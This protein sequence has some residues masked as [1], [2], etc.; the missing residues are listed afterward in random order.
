VV[1]IA[2]DPATQTGSFVDMDDDEVMTDADILSKR[3]RHRRWIYAG[4]GLVMVA[5]LVMG[6]LWAQRKPIAH[7]YLQNYLEDKGVKAKFDIKEIGTRFQRIENLVLGDPRNPDL[8]AEW[9]EIDTVANFSGI[10]IGAIRAK[11]VRLRGAYRD[12]KVSFG[13]LDQLRSTST[14]KSDGFP[15]MDVMIADARVGLDTDFGQVGMRFDG[16]GNFGST[17][18]GK[19]ALTAP[20]L[21]R[22]DCKGEGAEAWLDLGI[23]D[24]KLSVKGPVRAATV[25]CGE[26]RA[27]GVVLSLDGNI[28]DRFESGGGFFEAKV[29][30]LAS[31][32]AMLDNVS[33]W[34]DFGGNTRSISG[35]MKLDVGQSRL[36]QAQLGMTAIGAS[37]QLKRD[38][39]NGWNV[40]ANGTVNADN[41]RPDARALARMTKF[42]SAGDGTP[43]APLVTQLG[44]AIEGLG[45][46]SRAKARFDL[47]HQNGNG[48]FTLNGVEVVSKSGAV[49]TMAGRDPVRYLWR[50]GGL[51]VAGQA[52]L[53][54][55]GFPASTVSLASSDG[56]FSGTATIAPLTAGQ[57]RL[58]LSPVRFD[59][60]PN[61]T[62]VDTTA[63]FD[64][65]MNGIK[66]AGLQVPLSL[67]PGASP[68]NGCRTISLNRL[69]MA[70]ASFDPLSL[71]T[72]ISGN[73]VQVSQ[74]RASGRYQNAPFRFAGQ[75]VSFDMTRKIADIA[76]LNVS[77]S[78][79][80][81][82]FSATAKRAQVNASTQLA[83]IDA[84]EIKA[85]YGKAPVTIKGQSAQFANG[86]F[87]LK[88][89]YAHGSASGMSGTLVSNDL[90]YDTKAQALSASAIR[91]NGRAGRSPF[92][93]NAAQLTGA[94]RDFALQNAVVSYGEGASRSALNLSQLKGRMGAGGA[95]G[96]FTG[97]LINIAN[98]PVNMER[99][100]GQWQFGKGALSLNGVSLALSDRLAAPRYV[101]MQMRDFGMN[102]S[103]QGVKGAGG[104]FEPSTGTRIGAVDLD[105]SWLW[106]NGGLSLTVP[107]L[108]FTP[109]LQPEQLTSLTKGKIANVAGTVKGTGN[110]LW[111][112][113]DG[114][115]STGRFSTDGMDLAA[116]FGPVRQMKGTIEFDDLLNLVT[117]PGQ[118]VEIAEINSGVQ[119]TDGL[120]KYQLLPGLKAKVEGGRW[121]FSGGELFLEPTVLDLSETAERRLTFR[122][123]GLDAA[124][125]INQLELENIAATGTFDGVLPMIFD[126]QG[127]RIEAG[128][129]IV[130]DEGGTLS[131]ISEVSQENLGTYGMIA[132]DALKSLKYKRLAIDLG[133]PL[134]GEMVTKI[135]LN[136]VNQA[137]IVPGRARY[138]LPIPIKVSGLTGIPFL[139]NITIKAPFRG[140]IKM[141][142]DFQNPNDLIKETVDK[143]R[144]RLEAEAQKQNPDN[145]IQP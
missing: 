83:T 140:L 87:V 96:N 107:G 72:C 31:A 74:P 98:V 24:K 41:A 78:M 10:N 115:W 33:F 130:R 122:V 40:F 92:S 103:R 84:P 86:I 39:D 101:P 134:D 93:L 16:K 12:G 61:G 19:L 70:G 119:V 99:G 79:N 71:N 34:T 52:R 127:G 138:K 53:Q 120:I 109:E 46:G 112:S 63:T 73:T 89:P 28:N 5:P 51:M 126:S 111:S 35:K 25:Q 69:V 125:F 75:S 97:G 64:G 44:R 22:D 13:A 77:G 2:L 11:G 62:S 67:N 17:F 47:A 136:G 38:G 50:D 143:E 8:T 43:A 15:D 135:R 20:S 118:T 131:Y 129:M 4:L 27:D 142:R 132:F 116:A 56:R 145:P 133:G 76:G 48:R 113:R 9:A 42:R 117:A 68:F 54:G 30:Q 121:P 94:G 82:A 81:S 100:A 60:G 29:A 49:L 14:K 85:R 110:I 144:A 128:N 102:V 65:A 55:G 3:R 37:Y 91:L 21:I 95:S 23:K 88:N 18:T 26:T 106:G 80:G 32:Q 90:R 105:H 139:F 124:K 6:V 137:E 114:V 59:L 123:V 7:N 36:P 108:T 45:R 104:L 141:G 58:A 57:T 66:L 1:A